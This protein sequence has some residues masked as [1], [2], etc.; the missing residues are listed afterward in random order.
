MRLLLAEDEKSL[1]RA[2]V[3]ILEYNHYGQTIDCY[4]FIRNF[5]TKFVIIS[6]IC[7][8]F[9]RNHV[10]TVP[11]VFEFRQDKLSVSSARNF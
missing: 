6:G 9:C 10:N 11:M 1:S 8:K 3:A 4:P 7:K 5:T 2:L